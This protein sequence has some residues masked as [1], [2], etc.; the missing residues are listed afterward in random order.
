MANATMAVAWAQI[1]ANELQ[2]EA[3]HRTPDVGW[4]ETLSGH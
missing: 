4:A 1:A 2:A 3:R